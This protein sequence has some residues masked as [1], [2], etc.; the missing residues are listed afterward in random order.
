MHDERRTN[1]RITALYRQRTSASQALASRAREVLPSGIVHDSRH[2]DPH[3][4]YV[5]RAEGARKWDIDGN[6]PWNTA[7]FINHSCDPNAETMN[8][9]RRILIQAMKD[10]PKGEE[11]TYNYGYDIENYE[12]HPCHCGS[13]NCV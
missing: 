11:I 4:I 12:D 1:S 7:R 8:T 5:N 3:P 13:P 9:G 6:V 10:I 2:L